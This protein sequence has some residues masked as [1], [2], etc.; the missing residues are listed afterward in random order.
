MWPQASASPACRLHVT[1][2]S[3]QLSYALS[4]FDQAYALG[5]LIFKVATFNDCP[6]AAAE[7]RKEIEQARKD[8]VQRGFKF[9][10]DG[11]R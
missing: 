4:F 5:L 6:E 7:L 1:Y 11:G 2:R 9:V 3:K 8:L 10:D